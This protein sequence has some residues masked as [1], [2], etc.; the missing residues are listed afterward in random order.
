M[1]LFHVIDVPIMRYNL[2]KSEILPERNINY[3]GN[4]RDSAYKQY[5]TC[6]TIFMNTK[7]F[8]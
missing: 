4:Q 2:G 3:P 8:E 5:T 6:R 7:P 1:G